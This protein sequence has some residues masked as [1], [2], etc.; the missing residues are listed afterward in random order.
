MW[1]NGHIILAFAKEQ[2]IKVIFENPVESETIFVSLLQI[3][4]TLL[5]GLTGNHGFNIWP[6]TLFKWIIF[7]CYYIDWLSITQPWIASVFNSSLAYAIIAVGWTRES[8]NMKFFGQ[9]FSVALG[10]NWFR[11]VI[12]FTIECRT[13]SMIKGYDNFFGSLVAVVQPIIYIYRISLSIA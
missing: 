10:D 8:V 12:L 2:P 11:V 13:T 5:Y 4:F 3:R 7:Y 9:L 1:I 6:N